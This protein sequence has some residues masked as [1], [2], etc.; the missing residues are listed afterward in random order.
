M[1][2]KTGFEP[3]TSTLARWRSTG[4]SYFRTVPS[5]AARTISSAAEKRQAGPRPKG[6]S[7]TT[8]TPVN[9]GG[10]RQR[11]NSNQRYSTFNRPHVEP[12]A[13]VGEV[14]STG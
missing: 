2:R 14:I 11:E 8:T 3:A 4:L 12:W 7:R 1:E 13:A 6:P 9:E 10:R 5:S